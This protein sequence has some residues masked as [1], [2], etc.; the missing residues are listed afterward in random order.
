LIEI[1]VESPAAAEL[2]EA[3]QWH[4][5]QQEGLGSKFVAE[6]EA[7][8]ERVAQSRELY[9]PVY[10]S[11]R[12]ALLRRFP[13]AIYFILEPGVATITAVLHQRQAADRW[14]TRR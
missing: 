12:R 2:A 7:A 11:F 6:L 4:E 13:Y 10:R 5:D 1:R 14:Q 8:L 3:T 9:A